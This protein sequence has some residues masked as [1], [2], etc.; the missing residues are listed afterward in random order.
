M[1]TLAIF[2]DSFGAIKPDHE[3][4]GWVEKL[5]YHYAVTNFC[6][7]GSGQYRILQQIKSVDLKRFDKLLIT[8]TS[9]FRVFVRENLLHKNDPVYKNC[10]LIF[11]DIE[12]RDDEFSTA[13]YGYFK[14]I[15]D[16]EFYRDIHNLICKEIDRITGSFEC[17]HI[18]HFDYKDCYKFA[19][20]MCFHD[21]WKKHRGPVHHY[22][23]LGNHEIFSR[24]LDHL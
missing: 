19:N 24:V 14:Y 1:K 20:F 21:L 7:C 18:T 22:D 5:Q 8:H 17:L 13:A 9:P 15:F 16:H 10:D 11:A 12:N 6:Q 2:G 4:K 3:F 23:Q